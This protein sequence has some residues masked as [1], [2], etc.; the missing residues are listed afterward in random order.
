[1]ICPRCHRAY[2]DLSYGFCPEDGARLVQTL[3]AATPARPTRQFGAVLEDRYVIQGFIGAGGMSRVYLAADSRTKEQ[4]AVKILNHSFAVD[5]G[6]RERFLRELEV[7]AEIGHPNIIKVLDAGERKDG[8]PFIVLE[9]LTGES[10]GSML[11]R[12]GA[13]SEAVALPLIRQAASALSAAHAAGIIHRDVKPDNMFLVRSQAGPRV[14]KMM[15]FGFAKLRSGPATAAGIVLGTVPYMAPEQALADPVDG[16][17]DVYALGVTMFRMLTGQLPFSSPD[18]VLVVAQ[19]ACAE[20]PRLS[21]L[22]PGVDPR[23]E[24]LVATALRKLPRN[25]FDS[26]QSLLEDVERILGV[27]PGEPIGAPLGKTPDLYEPVSPA[28]REALKFLR[29][30]LP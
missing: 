7:A 21:A 25:R 22:R 12:E 5:R 28:A 20:A 18:D 6:Q 1:M 9:L 19:H 24:A 11:R 13:V 17:T 10:L 14:L 16:R 3:S 15:D 23:L 8:A 27:R 26:M 4:V 2:T 30:Q 29:R